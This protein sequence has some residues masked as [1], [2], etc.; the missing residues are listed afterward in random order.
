MPSRKSMRSPAARERAQNRP[1]SHAQAQRTNPRARRRNLLSARRIVDHVPLS[2]LDSRTR[3]LT[4]NESNRK[5]I[6]P[7][8]RVNEGKT[9]S[10]TQTTGFR[11][12][13]QPRCRIW[14]FCDE[15]HCSRFPVSHVTGIGVKS[16][17]PYRLLGSFVL[18]MDRK[19][20][21]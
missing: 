9:S 11:L 18:R 6:R 13:Y 17:F 19:D 1:A 3:A 12:L 10:F 14:I 2:T 20:R 16:F 4:P 5:I 7:L 21:G 15:E 8:R